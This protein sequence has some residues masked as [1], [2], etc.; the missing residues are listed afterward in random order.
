MEAIFLLAFASLSISITIV[1]ETRIKR[2][3]EAPHILTLVGAALTVALVSTG[4]WRNRT[5]DPGVTTELALLGTYLLGVMAMEH[6]VV[7]ADGSVVVAL[8]L[9]SRSTL[10]K[11]SV[12]F[13]A[14]TELCNAPERSQ[15]LARGP[16]KSRHYLDPAWPEHY[17]RLGQPS[18][19]SGW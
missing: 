7:A 8:L 3:L 4:Y 1:Q 19:F 17:S 13:L 14:A 5:R 12:D 2:E 18:Y 6:P 15:R 10:H 16:V 11:F 9:A